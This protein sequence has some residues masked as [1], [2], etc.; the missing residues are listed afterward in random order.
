[1]YIGLTPEQE[2]LRHELRAYYEKLLTPEVRVDLAREHGIGPKTTAVRKQMAQDGWLCFGWPKEYGGQGRDQV[3]HF[4]FFDESMRA[5][6]PIPMLTVNTVGP[7]IMRY[8]TEEQ[9]RFF[10]PKIATGELEFCIGYSEPNAGTDLASLQTR[11]VRDGDDYVVNGQKIWTSLAGGAD[12]CWLAVRTDPSASKHAGISMLIVDMK[13]A[14]IRVDPLHLLSEHDINQVFFDDVRVPAKNL[15]GG[16]NKGWKLITN[17]L[18]HERVTLCSSGVMERAYGITL[19][20]AKATRLADGRRLLDEEWVQVNLAKVYAGIEFLRLINWKVASTASKGALSPA[21]A[22]TTKVFGTEF[23]LDAFQWMM[24]IVGPQAY[25]K[26]GSPEA[27]AA[28]H[29]EG[30]YRSM[31]ILTFG[32]GVNEVQ[33][34]LIALF[35]LGLPR[36]PRH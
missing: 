15:V 16:E 2:K 29:L 22:S 20:Y 18:N 13:T 36:I 23:Y 3:D 28:G 9:K 26:R 25:L 11:A 33:R 14:G 10:L 4:I 1:M 30:L 32:G 31:M 27:V 19:D 35:G 24:E 21:D 5:A 8:G 7:T 6:A 34:D 17:Q 12:Y